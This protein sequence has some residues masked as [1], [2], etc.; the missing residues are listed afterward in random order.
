MSFN[1]QV[2]SR[3]LLVGLINFTAC[4]LVMTLLANFGLHYAIFTAAGYAV[5]F[6][7]S[8][9]LNFKF[10]FKSQGQ[11]FKRFQLF[12]VINLLNLLLVELIQAFYIELLHMPKVLAIG[13]GMGIYTMVGF[14]LN[15]KYVFAHAK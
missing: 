10:T 9:S 3:Y 2:L 5:A 11:V 7:V 1:I 4:I 6:L 8:F 14:L 12:V 15:Q 13:L